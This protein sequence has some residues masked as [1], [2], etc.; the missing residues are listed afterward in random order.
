VERDLRAHLLKDRDFSPPAALEGLRETSKG[1]DGESEL[2]EVNCGTWEEVWG[3]DVRE[4]GSE[5]GKAAPTTGNGL[6]ESR[7]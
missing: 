4:Y 7:P 2:W 3:A 6:V 5:Q 1:R